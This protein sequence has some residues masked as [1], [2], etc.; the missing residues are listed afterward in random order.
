M[1]ALDS[2]VVDTTALRRWMDERQLGDGDIS[3]LA[4]L[5]GGSQNILAGFRRGEDNFVLRMPP[6]HPRPT[7]NS[8][9]RR[10]ATV[11][12][13]LADTDI[14]V[15]RVLAT[16]FD[17]DVMQGAY[18]YLMQRVDG[19][20][21]TIELAPVHAESARVR[22]DMGLAA[23]A[24]LASLAE[25]DYRMLGLGNLG[26]PEDF[27]ARQ[28]PR[29]HSELESYGSQPGYPGPELPELDRVSEW[30]EG[31]RPGRTDPGIMHG[32]FHLANL[33]FRRDTAGIAAVIDWE[34]VTIGDPL[35]DLGWLLATWPDSLDSSMMGQIAAAGGLPSRR[36][37][38]KHYEQIRGTKLAHATW[39]ATLACFKL[40][41]LLEG[42]FARSCAGKAPKQLGGHMR[43][44]AQVL[45][46]RADVFMTSGLET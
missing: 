16:C 1:P 43:H 15:P 6:K 11:M 5:S 2:E 46:R 14:P 22:H 3:D 32:D 25:L 17:E 28:V 18:F 29:W 33:M 7:S 38:I 13:A 4:L 12:H 9:V 19:L 31:N 24:V 10:E 45:F 35:L 30:L 42:T 8:A 26:A 34:M 39:Y 40:G 23:A 44:L 20:N 41:I 21:P 27:I 37:L 36:E